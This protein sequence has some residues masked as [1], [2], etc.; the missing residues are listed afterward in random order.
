MKP[1]TLSFL[2]ASLLTIAA[3]NAQQA[4]TKPAQ[5][6]QVCFVLDTTGSM[7]GLIEGA[8]QKIWT[9][10][11]SIVSAQKGAHIEF[12]LIPYRDRGDQYVTKVF[13]LT[14]DIDKVYSDLQS[15]K[16]DG[17]GDEPESVNQAVN[18]AVRKIKWNDS[19]NVR[20]FI[21]LVGDAP[22]HMDYAD[23]VKFPDSC[24]TAARK[25]LII[26]TIQCGN[27]GGTQE[28][29]QKIASLAEGSYVAIPQS[30]GVVV[31]DTPMDKEISELS[32]KIAAQ[33]LAYGSAAQQQ[34]VAS[35]NNVAAAAPAPVAAERAAYNVSTGNKAIQGHGDLVSDLK[36]ETVQLDAIPNEQL[37]AAIKELPRDQQI[38]KI[39]QVTQ[40]RDALSKQVAE[41]AKKREAYIAEQN[42]KLDNKGDAFD[43]QVTEMLQKQMSRNP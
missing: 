31:I 13:D 11:N 1:Q 22:P 29:W 5:Q 38:Q 41:L 20:K 17:G 27:L 36:D 14:D 9:I 26:N 12:A 40:E 34:S 2:T 15:F 25:G 18:E 33:T 28:Y 43:A 4:A 7:S 6:I 21:F 32:T 37:P 19:P 24:Q 8:K 39:K 35:K 30:G 10:A 16:A 3:T 42:K 23:D